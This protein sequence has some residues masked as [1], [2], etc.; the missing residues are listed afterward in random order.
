MAKTKLK[1]L[2]GYDYQPENMQSILDAALKAVN[3]CK[4]YTEYSSLYSQYMTYKANLEALPTK[5]EYDR[6][7]GSGD[8]AQT[9]PAP[10]DNAA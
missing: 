2:T 9:T 5:D 8:G 7:H 3:K 6:E 10:D 1:A 4:K